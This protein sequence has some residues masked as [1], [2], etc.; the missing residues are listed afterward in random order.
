MSVWILLE[1]IATAAI[2]RRW[3]VAR[4]SSLAAIKLVLL[5]HIEVAFFT[6]IGA[7][8]IFMFVAERWEVVKQ[9]AQI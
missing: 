3:S 7:L 6:S 5:L 2:L 8:P 9:L 4:T 1:I